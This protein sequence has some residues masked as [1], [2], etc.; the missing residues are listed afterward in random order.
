MDMD[1]SHSELQP[2]AEK[3]RYDYFACCAIIAMMFIP[4]TNTGNYLRILTVL[5]LLFQ[6]TVKNGLRFTFVKGINEII[7]LMIGGTL[8]SIAFVFMIDGMFDTSLL[9]HE[10][11]RLGFNI[12]LILLTVSLKIPFNFIFK[13][14]LVVLVFHLGIQVMQKTGLF[15][16]NE[17]IRLVYVDPNITW[18]HLEL[19]EYGGSNFRSGSIFLNP[20]VYMVIPCLVLCLILQK[21]ILKREPQNY[22]F[23]FLVLVSLFLTGSR[24]IV[25]VF[26]AIMLYWFSISSVEP[27]EKT[28]AFFV[29]ILFLVGLIFTGDDSVS[30][31]RVFDVTNA[32]DSSLGI[33]VL[34][35]FEYLGSA[36]VIYYLWGSMGSMNVSN[37]QLDSEWG[38]IIRFYGLVGI[39]WYYKLIFKNPNRHDLRL[40]FFYKTARITILLVAVSATVFFCMPIFPYVCLLTMADMDIGAV[41]DNEL[42]AKE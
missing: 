37:S 31:A 20:N 42:I 32:V 36:N 16:I 40:S 35:L 11:I 8:I 22:I 5:L 18:S 21:N 17:W 12:L 3:V 28:A 38:F 2:P 6:K 13:S 15:N 33:K 34:N 39:I 1:H 10:L 19:S 7:G 30:S 24:T 25:F 14:S 29:A 27:Q 41:K 23:C 9:Q 26:A 4:M